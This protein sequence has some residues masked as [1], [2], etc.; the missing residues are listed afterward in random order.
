MSKRN[1]TR[2][3]LSLL[4][5]SALV[6]LCVCA[7]AESE[8]AL[9]FENGEISVATKKTVKVSPV[10]E[11]VENPKALKYVWA[12]SD[13][14]V[15]TVKN[16]TVKGIAPGEATV[17]CSAELPDGKQISASLQVH[18]V[19]PVK[20][21]KIETK[22]NTPVHVG[23][24]LAIAY[25]VQPENAT[26]KSLTWESSDPEI[27]E[28]DQSGAVTARSSGKVTITATANDGSRKQAKVSLYIPSLRCETA[29]VLADKPEGVTF[30]VDYFGKDWDSDVT[31]TATGKTFEYM[32][33]R[34]GN[35]AEFWVG[36]LG[37]GNG[38]IVIKD[39][40]DPKG[41]VTVAVTTEESGVGPGSAVTLENVSVSNTG[42]VYT[43][44]NN[45]PREIQAVQIIF[46]PMDAEGKL[47]F[48]SEASG[49]GSGKE[50]CFSKI[51]DP[52]KAGETL[53]KRF[54]FKAYYPEATQAL[55]AICWYS[56]DDGNKVV[57][58]EKDLRWFSTTEKRYVNFP[59]G[60]NTNSWY[61]GFNAGDL[62]SIEALGVTVSGTRSWHAKHFGYENAGYVVKEVTENSPAAKAGL[63][64]YDMIV[65]V[66]GTAYTDDPYILLRAND[67]EDGTGPMSLMVE[68]QG[69]EGLFEVTIT[70]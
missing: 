26:D 36:S 21:V 10:P 48:M 37:K 49:E 12:S 41:A 24:T 70:R 34:E 7:F 61:T 44:R 35:R 17:S 29:E 69:K 39:R 30:S 8:P 46:M 45:S 6:C 67:A 20:S 47:L 28:V 58:A 13:E 32:V 31:V 65:S 15:A 14:Q 22:A 5:L 4:L 42:I 57:F 25:T 19:E 64:L 66:N 9:R 60:R 50:I 59:E 2:I 55:A 56:P 33:Q 38:K 43:V 23:E 40:K 18:V 68:R 51:S 11:N 27:A 1:T 3:L 16:G 54:K 62:H 53:K 52:I 63:Q